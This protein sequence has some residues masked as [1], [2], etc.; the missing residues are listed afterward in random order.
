[1]GSVVNGLLLPFEWIGRGV[2]WLLA[3]F[4][5][6]A[7]KWIRGR[8]KADGTHGN[9]GFATIPELKMD[10]HLTPGGF[11]Y[12]IQEGQRVYALREG[13]VHFFGK[14]GEGKSQTVGANLSYFA[15]RPKKPDI[16]INDSS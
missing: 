15:E 13:C 3:W 9:A 11:L 14:R 1:M 12:G 6:R 4:I 2:Y 16:V 7:W 5:K 10:G 8:K